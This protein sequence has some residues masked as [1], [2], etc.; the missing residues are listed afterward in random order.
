MRIPLCSIMDWHR[1]SISDEL[2]EKMLPLLPEHKAHHPLGTHRRRGDNRAA[3]NPIFFVLRICCHWNALNASGICSSSCSTLR[4][5]Q[6][7]RD[8]G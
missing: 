7:W 6:E 2:R 3:M 8:A 4:R 1:S 5:F